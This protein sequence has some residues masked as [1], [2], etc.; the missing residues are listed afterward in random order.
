MLPLSSKV[1]RQASL[2]RWDSGCPEGKQRP[3][4]C[5]VSQQT[6]MWGCGSV[7]PL[8]LN[9]GSGEDRATRVAPADTQFQK[10]AL[11]VLTNLVLNRITTWQCKKWKLW[12]DCGFLTKCA[13][14]HQVWVV[15]FQWCRQLLVAVRGM[16]KASESWAYTDVDQT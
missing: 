5:S 1:Q 9:L 11:P 6:C 10:H 3:G 16:D 2:C 8:I 4:Q 13:V 12:F 15:K 14:E 7:A